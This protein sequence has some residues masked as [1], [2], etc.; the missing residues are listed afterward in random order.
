M[1]LSFANLYLKCSV[2]YLR[3]YASKPKASAGSIHSKVADEEGKRSINGRR[4][5]HDRSSSPRK[6][7]GPTMH[8]ATIPLLRCW[9]LCNFPRTMNTIRCTGS[10]SLITWDNII[11]LNQ[12]CQGLMEIKYRYK[13]WYTILHLMS[14]TRTFSS[15]EKT[16][17]ST[18]SHILSRIRSSN[19]WN[20]GTWIKGKKTAYKMVIEPNILQI[21]GHAIGKVFM[22]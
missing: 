8:V 19:L 1:S 4:R 6:F 21:E 9:L 12:E 16:R 14:L 13:F 7:P 22:C 3:W 20:S 15:L 10:P 17:C 2:M 18:L 5:H 11:G